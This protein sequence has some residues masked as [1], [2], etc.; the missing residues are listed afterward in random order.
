V[1]RPGGDPLPNLLAAGGAAVG[2]SGPDASGYL[3]G[4]GLLTAVVLGRIAG[5]EA[6]RLAL[7]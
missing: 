6:A 1:L 3:S 4:N 2:V 5:A 7:A